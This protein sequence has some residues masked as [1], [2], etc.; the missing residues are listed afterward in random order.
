MQPHIHPGDVIEVV[1]VYEMEHAAQQRR[2]PKGHRGTVRGGGSHDHIRVV[3]CGVEYSRLHFVSYCVT[4]VTSCHGVACRVMSCVR[5]VQCRA[6][7]ITI[8]PDDVSPPTSWCCCCCFCCCCCQVASVE[9]S[10]ALELTRPWPFF[11]RGEGAGDN[12]TVFLVRLF[13]RVFF[14]LFACSIGLV[15]GGW[16]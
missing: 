8:R 7:I 5:T 2:P 9:D 16:W 13:F 1:S 15:A 3:C 11:D 4:F 14:C 6:V 10:G 12:L